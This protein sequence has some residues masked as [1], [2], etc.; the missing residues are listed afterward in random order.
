M[1]TAA[2]WWTLVA[3][4]VVFTAVVAVFVREELDDTE[5]AEEPTRILVWTHAPPGRPFTIP[6]A[7]R[8]MQL[9]KACRREDCPRKRAAYQTLRDA[10]R[11]KPDSGRIN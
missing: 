5:T 9:H 7:H 2:G 1:S 10:G 8:V 4:V 11:L 3:L 6:Q